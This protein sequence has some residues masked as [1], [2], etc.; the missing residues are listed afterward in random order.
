MGSVRALSSETWL[1][2]A[3]GAI[4]SVRS[5]IG[6]QNLP[7]P[8]CCKAALSSPLSRH[9]DGGSDMGLGA[10]KPTTPLLLFDNSRHSYM[11]MAGVLCP[12]AC[13]NAPR[14]PRALSL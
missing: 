5:G 8:L 14:G 7:R 1:D 10:S 13:A 2:D 12:G 6:C 11:S 3:L 9:T 4:C